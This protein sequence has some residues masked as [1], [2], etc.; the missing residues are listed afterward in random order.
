MEHKELP[1]GYGHDKCRHCKKLAKLRKAL[2][3]YADPDTY[4]A[5]GFLPDPPCGDF[6]SDFGKAPDGSFKPG[7]LAREV[8]SKS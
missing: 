3:L 5:I 1:F 6:I 4:F 7:K 2:E 8:L